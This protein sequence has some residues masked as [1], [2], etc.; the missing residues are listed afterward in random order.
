MAKQNNVKLIIGGVVVVAAAFGLGYWL[1]NLM[2]RRKSTKTQEK[3]EKKILKEAYDNLTFQ[4]NKSIIEP[5][6]YPFLDEI[7]SVMKQPEASTWTIS[8]V[9]HT[10]NVGSREYNQKL[11]VSRANAV[12]RYLME[13][14]VAEARIS[15]TGFGEDKPIADNKTEEGRKSNRRVEFTIKK[16]QGEQVTTAQESVMLITPTPTPT[17]EKKPVVP[18][19][20]TTVITTNPIKVN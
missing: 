9:G 2:K 8:I 19:N 11:S 1:S 6:S 13:K 17:E 7:V 15:T 10:D 4:T 16:P 12:K 3:N 14:G 20:E 5:T 18:A